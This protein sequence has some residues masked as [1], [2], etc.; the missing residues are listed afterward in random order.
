MCLLRVTETLETYGHPRTDILRFA[1]LCSLLTILHRIKPGG[2]TSAILAG[3]NTGKTAKKRAAEGDTCPAKKRKETTARDDPPDI[4]D[5]KIPEMQGQIDGLRVL[6]KEVNDIRKEL[7]NH[8]NNYA[9]E[10]SVDKL[11][12]SHQ[13]PCSEDA[14]KRTKTLSDFMYITFAG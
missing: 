7:D 14:P 11:R 9:K 10:D 3:L 13:L 2:N 4:S 8:V 12:R 6:V 1:P 5:K